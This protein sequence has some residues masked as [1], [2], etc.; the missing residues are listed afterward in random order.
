[1]SG[2][3]RSIV[4]FER[5]YLASLLLSAVVTFASWDYWVV[6]KAGDPEWLEY[7]ILGITMVL[8]IF[9]ILLWSQIMTRRSNI[10]KWALV[11]L[12]LG[13]LPLYFV[14]DD[15]DKRP[16]TLIAAEIGSTVLGVVATF[17]LF[18]PAARQWFRNEP[19]NLDEIFR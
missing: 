4:F 15:T 1:M 6:P 3:P 10:A 19:Q 8:Y 14:P 16:A 5:G 12:T 11:V 13:A 17:A 18:T 9:S 7:A 2:S